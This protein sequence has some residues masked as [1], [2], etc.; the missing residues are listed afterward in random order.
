M[1]HKGYETGTQVKTNFNSA[2]FFFCLIV[3]QG[4]VSYLMP[5]LSL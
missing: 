1:T 2:L 5:E 4:F 3:M